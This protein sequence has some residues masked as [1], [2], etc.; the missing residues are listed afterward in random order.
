MALCHRARHTACHVDVSRSPVL[1]VG[2]DLLPEPVLATFWIHSKWLV[3]LSTQGP[4]LLSHGAQQL[5]AC[6]LSPEQRVPFTHFPCFQSQ[7]WTPPTPIVMSRADLLLSI[8]IHPTALHTAGPLSSR[9]HDLSIPR[10]T[11]ACSHQPLPWCSQLRSW[12]Q[13]LL[14]LF[15]QNLGGNTF[16]LP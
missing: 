12:Y 5:L 9:H 2:E 16:L 10:T 8:V 7:L 11:P 6:V 14:W 4:L 13:C 15:T 1:R 3:C